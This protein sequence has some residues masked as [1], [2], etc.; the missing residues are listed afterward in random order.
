MRT[1]ND[2]NSLEIIN[3]S[4]IETLIHVFQEKMSM[5]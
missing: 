1:N 2:M 3:L 5:L 4:G